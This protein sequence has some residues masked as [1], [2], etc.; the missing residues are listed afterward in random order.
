MEGTAQ[1]AGGGFPTNWNNWL[2]SDVAGLTSANDNTNDNQIANHLQ[3]YTVDN[4]PYGHGYLA[5]AYAGYLANGGGAVTAANIA[6]G[7]NRIFTDLLQPGSDLNTVLQNRTGY[8]E[9]QLKNLFAN[10]DPGLVAFV[11]QLAYNTGS[12]GA[13]S[14]IA[15][16]GLSSGGANILGNTAPV[17]AFQIEG[18]NRTDDLNERPRKG[19]SELVLQVG[20]DAGEQIRIPLFRMDATALGLQ[21][22]NTKTAEAAREMIDEVAAAIGYVSGV[23]TLY[24]ALQ[25][26][27]EHTIKNLDN[28]VENTTSAE[29]VIRDQDMA[30]A[31]VEYSNLQILQ[32]TG[33]AVLSQA[34]HTGDALLTLLNS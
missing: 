4:R 17:Q 16:G 19:G 9:Q 27:L 1:L 32:Q 28:V 26:R 24:G 2:K 31:M 21:K 12:A 34:N 30:D 7:M 11:R 15:P 5:A 29:S 3:A 13:G 23:R 10:G 20:V 25:N 8:T 33:Q 22:A 6:A 14:V 18:I